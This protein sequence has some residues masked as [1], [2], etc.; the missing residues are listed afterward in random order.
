M[1]RRP[2]SGELAV[3]AEPA[4]VAHLDEKIHDADRPDADLV[5]QV[6]AESSQQADDPRVDGVDAAVEAGDL[7]R[8]VAQAA[9]LHPIGG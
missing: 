6:R 9:L 2:T 3:A 7:L 5:G 4:R 1:G 8:G